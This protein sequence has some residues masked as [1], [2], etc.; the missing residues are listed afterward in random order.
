MI[1][2]HHRAPNLVTL[3]TA[4]IKD[5]DIDL[6]VTTWSDGSGEVAYRE[7]RWDTW[8]APVPLVNA[9]SAPQHRADVAVD[10]P[11]RDYVARTFHGYHSPL[12]RRIEAVTS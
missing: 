5:L 7:R 11:S 4:H 6:L 3:A 12:H 1:P 9:P 8:S 2:D 10:S